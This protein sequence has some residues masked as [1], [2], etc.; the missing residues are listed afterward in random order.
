MVK[1]YKAA[2]AA[3]IKP[4]VGADCWIRNDA[5]REKPARLLLLCASAA[6]YR[7]LSELLSRASAEREER[8]WQEELEDTVNAIAGLTAVDGATILNERG[9]L[10]AFGAKI[11]RRKGQ[12]VLEQAALTEPIEGGDVS[13]VNTAQL[14]GT[15]H[16]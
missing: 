2:R 4:I 10:L 12:P 3:G 15:R 14:G 1:F 13:I 11:S 9:E 7:K 8:E 6:G 5:D 16:L